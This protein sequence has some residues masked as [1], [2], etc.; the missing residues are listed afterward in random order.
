MGIRFFCPNGHKLHV[1]TEQGGKVGY[2]PECNA[3]MRIPL[4]STRAHGET[5]VWGKS[6][7]AEALPVNGLPVKDPEPQ[8]DPFATLDEIR[9]PRDS[10]E[11][12]TESARDFADPGNVER[13]GLSNA[14]DGLLNAD[15]A[16]RRLFGDAEARPGK[17]SAQ[18]A[19]ETSQ[20]FL[21]SKIDSGRL[22]QSV[23]SASDLSDPYLKWYVYVGESQYGPVD[24]SVIVQWISERRISS[25]TLVWR[26]DW[27]GWRKA[28]EIFPSEIEA[29]FEEPNANKKGADYAASAQTL[30]SVDS[31]GSVV[32]SK[33]TSKRAK[34]R[35]NSKT[36][37]YIIC[38]LILVCVVLLAVLLVVL[39][40]DFGNSEGKKDSNT[41]VEAIELNRDAFYSAKV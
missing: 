35:K 32:G 4:E 24:Y 7:T 6:A 19:V 39:F 28:N 16:A 9:A 10:K 27:A 34:Q 40:K 15:D 8:A 33:D 31:V 36:T 21:D 13:D 26:Q 17:N 25:T 29:A 3:R 37:L 2:C 14:G 22:Y 1:K 20:N 41:N 11:S 18:D 38:G 12:P 23:V 30:V 5:F